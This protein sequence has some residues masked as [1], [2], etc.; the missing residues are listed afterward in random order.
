MPSSVLDFNSFDWFERLPD[1][2]VLT[3]GELTPS[4]LRVPIRDAK[5][6][7]RQV[8]RL[9]LNLPRNSSAK[10]VWSQGGS[11]LLIHSNSVTVSS[12]SGVITITV[13]VEC[14]QCELVNIPVPIGVGTENSPSGLLMT[15]FSDLD[16]PKEIVD[17]WTDAL[18][19]FA[20]ETLLEIASLVSS[21]VGKD[22]RGRALV[23]GS[24]GA[25]PGALLI[26]TIA[27]HPLS[28]AV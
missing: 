24:I 17:T 21:E 19:A 26:Q 23:P 5:V 25:A 3:A 18:T 7:V 11:E 1:G 2:S 22:S 4:L 14:D 13:G 16:G 10:V 9:V 27:R 6:I 12:S 20:W 28:A 8:V 15:A